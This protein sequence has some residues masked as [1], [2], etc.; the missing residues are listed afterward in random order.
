MPQGLTTP[1]WYN[2]DTYIKDKVAECNVIRFGDAEQ[3]PWTAESVRSFLAAANGEADYQPW[4]GYENF[5]SNGNAENCSPNPLFNVMEYLTAKANQ[6]NALDEGAGY[7]GS[8]A[9]TAESV[10]RYFND[11]GITAWDHFTTAGQFEGVN[12][13]NAMDLS[14]F[15]TRKAAQCNEMQFDDRDD[16]TPESVLA[17]YQEHGI[18]AV[19]VAV[20]ASDP[21]VVAVPASEAVTVPAGETPWGDQ[22]LTDVQLT[23]GQDVVSDDG[24]PTNFIGDVATS[25][26][27]STFNQNDQI[28]ATNDADV[29]TLAMNSSFQGMNRGGF[30]DGIKTIDLT[31]ETARDLNFN[32]KGITGAD[33]YNIDGTVGLQN[34]EK[35]GI[36]VNYSD[37]HTNSNLVVGFAN[38][39]NS[40]P[41]DSLTVGL[42]D[43]YIP[44][45]GKDANGN[46]QPD[47]AVSLV[48]QAIEDLTIN[49]TG[50]HDNHIN[51]DGVNYMRSLEI[52]GDQDLHAEVQ[53]TYLTTIDG[54]AAKGDLD[55]SIG[56]DSPLNG[57]KLGEGDDVIRAWSISATASIDGGAGEDNL[58][59]E[60]AHNNY[61]L[62]SSEVETLTLANT[63]AS[64]IG[65]VGENM[66][67]V[68]NLVLKNVGNAVSGNTDITL[69]NFPNS[70][71]NVQAV[72]QNAVDLS[73][74]DIPVV[75]VVVGDGKTFTNDSLTGTLNLGSATNLNITADD[76]INGANPTFS[77]EVNANRVNY[78]GIDAANGSKVTLGGQT[79]LG[80]L[81]N[82][83][84]S[85]AGDV[86]LGSAG[87]L[88]GSASRSVYVN[89]EN[90]NGGTFTGYF[91]GNTATD[92]NTA[93][94]AVQGS[95]L[96]NNVIYVDGTYGDIDVNTGMG[97]DRLVIQ[98]GSWKP[99]NLNANLGGGVNTV[100]VR[101]NVDGSD[102]SGITG[103]T[104][105]QFTDYNEASF[106]EAGIK[107][108]EGV[109]SNVLPSGTIPPDQVWEDDAQDVP[110]TAKPDATVQVGVDNP[111]QDL[112][113]VVNKAEGAEGTQSNAVAG[114]IA[115]AGKLNV[116]GG[117][118]GIEMNFASGAGADPSK[119]IVTDKSQSVIATG[120]QDAPNTFT[121]TVASVESAAI[122][123]G[124]KNDTVNLTVNQTKGQT[125]AITNTGGASGEG[126]TVNVQGAGD[127]TITSSDFANVAVSASA[128]GNTT[129]SASDGTENMTANIAGG[130]ITTI[131]TNGAD[132]DLKVTGG[133]KVV[134][135]GAAAKGQTTNIS[136]S[137]SGDAVADTQLRFE[138]S[139]GNFAVDG[140]DMSGL[141]NL[142]TTGA[143]QTTVSDLTTTADSFNLTTDNSV[144]FE[145]A[146]M[147][148]VRTF[149]IATGEGAETAAAAPVTIS[150]EFDTSNPGA[151]P[152]PLGL[153]SVKE[154]TI[155]GDQ[156]VTI[157][158]ALGTRAGEAVT[159]DASGANGGFT[160][161]GSGI[162]T[163]GGIFNGG[164]GAD[165]L[166]IAGI[167]GNY[168][169]NMGK[170]ADTL[171]VET[172]W[173]TQ[174]CVA[175]IDVDLGANDDAADTIAL[176]GQ[177]GSGNHSNGGAYIRVSNFVAANDKLGT[178]DIPVNSASTLGGAYVRWG[179]ID[180]DCAKITGFLNAFLGAGT[181]TEAALKA[182]GAYTSDGKFL[183]TGTGANAKTYLAFIT[184]DDGSDQALGDS[185]TVNGCALVELVGVTLNSTANSGCVTGDVGA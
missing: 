105:I 62:T 109:S 113:I 171:L 44:G 56:S 174:G 87:S 11:H 58:V 71:L 183:T 175:M 131:D 52:N 9:W 23:A 118:A 177:K 26:S 13:S 168:D 173:G 142:S 24:M 165:S 159:I 42:S 20:N 53:G 148:S 161:G 117:T 139:G 130:D 181:I 49:S 112:G 67:G 150:G 180:S 83:D 90:M 92:N 85:G 107:L 166:V 128:T 135:D 144:V 145:D 125:T 93:S 163:A 119:D 54:S 60:G 134:V 45:N 63:N 169:M 48:A 47:Y 129:L 38:G 37:V 185:A 34:L 55:L 81:S 121:G 137:I 73:I 122:T 133:N 80:A 123:T 19:E 28:T 36:T 64:S 178:F 8:N 182:D 127:T 25:Q 86:Q 41:D 110:V 167:A 39:V 155:T 2:D 162:N 32:T 30:V 79:D 115:E 15:L 59:L 3:L 164:N 96:A 43:V 29:L 14:E 132:V 1:N 33:T 170:G 158:C 143:A 140:S 141:A 102:F 7:E 84:V 57:V 104:S 50:P 5:V 74:A 111:V 6:L 66:D 103:V 106:K 120:S 149:N 146:T 27:K 35:T 88:I 31:N 138:G 147:N 89:T 160:L 156:Q 76:G 108:G 77:A 16:W 151:A 46:D 94:L 153:Q 184:N 114:A 91:T 17:Y 82:V 70:E 116:A 22:V 4:M 40:G 65:L 152:K 101:G 21:N 72:N 157:E 75:N 176:W 100:I 61:A 179:N 97:S 12:P 78:L 51:L 95:N 126:F 18:N 98:G 136:G 69:A 99:N 172:G 68:E 154:L 10:L 124:T